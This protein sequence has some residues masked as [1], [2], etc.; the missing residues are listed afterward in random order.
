MEE[1]G[2]E[3]RRKGHYLKT[4]D[5]QKQRRTRNIVVFAIVAVLCVASVLVYFLTQRSVYRTLCTAGYEG[6]QEQW[7]ASLVGEELGAQERSAYELAVENGYNKPYSVWMKT[8]TGVATEDVQK[9]P[10][11]V[12]CENGCEESLTQW[13]TQIAEN[14]KS[15]GRSKDGEEQ[16][17]YELACEYG[18]IGPSGGTGTFIEWLVSLSSDR[19]F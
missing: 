18:Y 9:T 4:E 13:L 12:A 3:R 15:L 2:M 16:T 11:Q 8:L 19:V 5:R 1:S 14:P 6:T 7:L 17:A 10:Y